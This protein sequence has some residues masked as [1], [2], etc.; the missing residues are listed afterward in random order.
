MRLKIPWLKSLIFFFTFIIPAHAINF[1]N[2][3]DKGK[4]NATDVTVNCSAFSKNLSCS[5][6]NVQHALNTIDQLNSGGGSGSGNVGIGTA[7]WISYY[8][9]NG[10]TVVAS[11]A[12]QIVNGN[13]GIGTSIVNEGL[14]SAVNSSGFP[15]PDT[16]PLA[17]LMCPKN[18]GLQIPF[19]FGSCDRSTIYGYVKG[20]TGGTLAL[21]SLGPTVIE[22]GGFGFSNQRFKVDELGNVGIGVNTPQENLEV[23][24][25][26][27]TDG[28]IIRTPDAEDDVTMADLVLKS[29]SR[30]G[31]QGAPNVYIIAGGSS[32]PPT[33]G[34]RINVLGGDDTNSQGVNIIGGAQGSTNGASLSVGG[35]IQ[36]ASGGDI[37]SAAGLTNDFGFIRGGNNTITSG[38]SID[39]GAGNIILI[40]GNSGD[41]TLQPTNGSILQTTGNATVSNPGNFTM[42]IGTGGNNKANWSVIPNTTGGYAGIKGALGIGNTYYSKLQATSNNLI[43]EGNL[44]IGSFIPQ[45]KLDV[46]GTVR[47]IQ[48]IGDGSALS[49]LPSSGASGWTLGASNV[50]ISTTNNVGIGTNLTTTAALTVMG[51]NVGIGTWVPSQLLQVGT[52]F[53]VNSG[54][55][56]TARSFNVSAGG[57]SSYLIGSVGALSGGSSLLQMGGTAGGNWNTLKFNSGTTGAMLIDTNGNVGIGS[58]SPNILLNVI[59][60][61]GIGTMTNNH[62]K[63][64]LTGN[65]ATEMLRINDS[66][67]NDTTPALMVTST[68]NVGIGTSIAGSPFVIGANAVSITS[69]GSITATNISSSFGAIDFGSSIVLGATTSMGIGTFFSDNTIQLRSARTINPNNSAASVL[70][71]PTYTEGASGV[72]P[73]IAGLAIRPLTIT[74]GTATTTNAYSAIIEGPPTG[75]ATITNPIMSLGVLSGNVGFGTFSG[76]VNVG[77]GS[78]SPGQ[79]LDVQGNIRVS[80]LGSTLAIKTGSNACKGQATLASG[81]VTVST[82]CTPSS[83]EGI[84][85]TDATTGAL[86]NIGTPTVGT[87][88]GAT[89]FIIN[90]SNVLDSS[91][92]NW[93]ILK[94]S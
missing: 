30:S 37:L 81:T 87:I 47:A 1:D 80:L 85:L 79:A 43:V 77:I 90:S 58:L 74:N 94:S 31:S 55:D 21:G 7:N 23:L 70:I 24:G 66:G 41:P 84:F 15:T 62:A 46:A 13:V 91:N 52:T 83:S 2:G 16:D 92:V 3:Y 56:S 20:D 59:G 6:I 18:G 39:G 26:I 11:S 32:G 42:T 65:G 64:E 63:L 60:N 50:G 28:G 4:L 48:F 19:A 40:A 34:G 8:P 71:N 25:N 69:S 86:T 88:V 14:V 45:S 29:G 27:L 68:G 17:M 93:V 89:S 72:H 51:G 5:D 9:V 61:V 35:S 38:S 73:Y 22:T 36:G 53:L 10:S 12:I 54:G 33:V 78:M 82:T 49:N 67:N 44:G 57:G 75:T 76:A